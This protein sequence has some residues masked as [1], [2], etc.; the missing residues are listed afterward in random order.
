MA[1]SSSK[2]KEEIL[3]HSSF[4]QVVLT[5]IITAVTTIVV[6]LISTG[7][8]KDDENKSKKVSDANVE[9][10]TIHTDPV[11]ASL[12]SDAKDYFIWFNAQYK[13]ATTV[14]D[15]AHYIN[16]I[17]K[18]IKYE[19]YLIQP[20]QVNAKDF[21]NFDDK[22]TDMRTFIR[23]INNFGKEEKYDMPQLLPQ[24]FSEIYIFKEDKIPS[25]SF[26]ITKDKNDLEKVI[27]YIED[28]GYFIDENRKPL[29]CF[30]SNDQSL[31][32]KFESRYK[33][34]ENKSTPSNVLDL[35]KLLSDLPN[36]S[37]YIQ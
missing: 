7:Q 19:F 35:N 16:I 36:R 9:T 11:K 20:E 13:N 8:F 34:L 15:K 23:K 6:T 32:K 27:F 21:K 10:T 18:R 30:E 12:W 14:H 37:F 1:Q 31:I 3:A 29:I 2:S 24:I 17:K 33:D 26:F 4:K 22:F 5:T 25:Y 28:K